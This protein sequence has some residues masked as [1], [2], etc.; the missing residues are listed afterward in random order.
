MF[1]VERGE[2][3]KNLSPLAR[4]EIALGWCLVSDTGLEWIA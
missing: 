2:P 3:I 1:I 4:G